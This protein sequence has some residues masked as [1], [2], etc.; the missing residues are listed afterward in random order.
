MQSTKLPFLAR[1]LTRYSGMPGYAHHTVDALAALRFTLPCQRIRY[2]KWYGIGVRLAMVAG[3]WW[4]ENRGKP[5]PLLDTASRGR[6][7]NC[8]EAPCGQKY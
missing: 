3:G 5:P 1:I 6:G 2:A 8:A 7:V 4:I